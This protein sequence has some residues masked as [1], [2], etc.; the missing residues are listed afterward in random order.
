MHEEL[1]IEI[2]VINTNKNKQLS[3]KLKRATAVEEVIDLSSTYSDTESNE[4]VH[5]NCMYARNLHYQTRINQGNDEKNGENNQ[6]IMVHQQS[7]KSKRFGGFLN[8][9]RT[10]TQSITHARYA[11]I[12]SL[13]L[14]HG[15]GDRVLANL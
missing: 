8:A 13:K 6:T 11:L 15:Q 7:H 2:L 14:A 9:A 5:A 12:G 4:I 1:C 3:K 10:D